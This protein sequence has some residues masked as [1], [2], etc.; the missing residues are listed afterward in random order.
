MWTVG[1]LQGSV[2][3][4]T[5]FSI[6]ICEGHPEIFPKAACFAGALWVTA[7][8]KGE[9]VKVWYGQLGLSSTSRSCYYLLQH[10]EKH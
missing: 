1:E 6:P 8:F 5:D 3:P 10:T 9:I 4:P 2:S 7:M